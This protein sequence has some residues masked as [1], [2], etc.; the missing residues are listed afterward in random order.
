MRTCLDS[1]AWQLIAPP[2]RLTA[3][4]TLATG[5]SAPN[6]QL[7][8]PASVVRRQA[9]AAAAVVLVASTFWCWPPWPATRTCAASSFFDPLTQS[10]PDSN[11]VPS[12][13]DR[14]VRFFALDL[15]GTSI[16][17]SLISLLA[18]LEINRICHDIKNKKKNWIYHVHS[19]NRV[20]RCL[21]P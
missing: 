9:V 16:Q 19:L 18:S 1:S 7:R 3:K 11:L 21:V 14:S 12:G 5:C 17:F 2:A 10:L 4:A 8:S 15:S 13:Q 20:G 6:R